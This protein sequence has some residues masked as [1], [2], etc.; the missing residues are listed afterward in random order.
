MKKL[1]FEGMIKMEERSLKI[2]GTDRNFFSKITSTLTKIL[3]P[4]K[5][6]INGMLISIKRNSIIKAF[7]NFT[8]DENYDDE[9]LEKKYNSA[10]ETYLDALDKYVMDSIYKIYYIFLLIFL[11]Q[12]LL[13]LHNLILINIFVFYIYILH[14]H[15]L[16]NL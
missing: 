2:V 13:F 16:L 11:F 10:Y 3:I 6:G 1:R 5:I 9:E 4:T 12:I 14:I 15:F 8:K 7:E